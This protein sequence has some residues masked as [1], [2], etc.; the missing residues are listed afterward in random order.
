MSAPPSR[1]HVILSGVEESPVCSIVLRPE[2]HGNTFAR[3]HP[4]PDGILS[5]TILA[6]EWRMHYPD[7]Y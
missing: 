3:R 1:P 4:Q 6:N 2:T 5:M 7:C